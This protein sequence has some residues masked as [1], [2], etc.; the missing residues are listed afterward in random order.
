MSDPSAAADSIANWSDWVPFD[1]VT[2]ADRLPGVYMARLGSDGLVI[3]VG[4]AGPRAGGG[5]PGLCGR[6]CRYA[7]GKGIVSGLG[8]AA[9]DRALADGEWLRERLAEVE[10]G[11]PM[12]AQDWGRA[13]MKRPGLYVRWTVTADKASAL[14]LRITEIQHCRSPKPRR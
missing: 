4:M 5:I 6:L 1:Q 14:V 3:Y 10:S 9:A 12:T 2:I 8:E 13:A 7:S 11:K